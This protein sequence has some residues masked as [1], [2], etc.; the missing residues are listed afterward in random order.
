MVVAIDQPMTFAPGHGLFELENCHARTLFYPASYRDFNEP[1]QW[2]FPVVTTYWFV[3]TGYFMNGD[4]QR[5]PPIRI[6]RRDF[7]LL[8]T[9]ISMPDLQPEQWLTDP[10]YGGT[11][12]LI[13]T[14][15]YRHRPTD[16][17]LTV[18]RHKRRGPSALR[19]EVAGISAFFYRRD[20]NEGGSGTWW[21]SETSELRKKKRSLPKLIVEKLD[22]GGWIV[23]DGSICETTHNPY[24][25]FKLA[26]NQCQKSRKLDPWSK[27]DDLGN[28]FDCIGYA[29]E[30]YGPVLIWKVTKPK[31]GA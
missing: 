19:K 8:D 31:P 26:S 25:F 15:R 24:R 4:T 16:T 20:S 7:Q 27:E 29:G 17:I 11:P 10:K 9:Q 28:R 3:D 23:T 13:R 5:V 2:F 1:I 22:D 14:D 21:L 6:D 18:H 30:G 12:P